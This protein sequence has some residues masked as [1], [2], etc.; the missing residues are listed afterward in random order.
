MVFT[1]IL[2]R[3]FLTFIIILG[4]TIIAFVLV[5]LTPGDPARKMLPATATEEQVLAM[6]QRMGLDKPLFIQYGMY[7]SNILRGDL[8]YSFKYK[9]NVSE[10]I[11]PRLWKTAQITVLGVLLALIDTTRHGCRN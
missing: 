10:L 1:R 9:M 8:G 7:I 2:R 11:F 6:R 5:R 3:V 4:V